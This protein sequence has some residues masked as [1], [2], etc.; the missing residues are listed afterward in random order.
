MISYRKLFII[1]LRIVFLFGCL[2]GS[3]FIIQHWPHGRKLFF[4]S[5]FLFA[6]TFVPGILKSRFP[7]VALVRIYCVFGYLLSFDLGYLQAPYWGHILFVLCQV[8]FLAT[9]FVK[10][11]KGQ[12]TSDTSQKEAL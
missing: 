3:I 4:V 6:I 5:Q 12:H 9:F 7:R 11:N 10:M 1:I 2:L 8:L